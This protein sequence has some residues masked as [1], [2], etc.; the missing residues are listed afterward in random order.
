MVAQK[1]CVD[2]TVKVC[3]GDDENKFFDE[4]KCG[5]GGK[6]ANVTIDC[7]GVEDSIRRGILVTRYG[8]K[9]VL[10]GVAVGC[11]CVPIVPVHHEVDIIGCLRYRNCYGVAVSLVENK[12]IDPK[13]VVTHC[14]AL[15]EVQK[16]FDIAVCKQGDPIKILVHAN[17]F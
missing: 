4:V 12:K 7:A 11:A 5:F 9:F 10:V 1:M 13:P 17:T 3:P 14:F 16:A 8:G 15:E 6:F 2:F